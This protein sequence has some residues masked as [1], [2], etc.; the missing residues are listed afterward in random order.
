MSSCVRCGCLSKSCSCPGGMLIGDGRDDPT[1]DYARE[2]VMR[3]RAAAARKAPTSTPVPEKKQA[4]RKCGICSGAEG[5]THVGA[6]VCGPC[7][8]KFREPISGAVQRCILCT[9]DGKLGVDAT[10]VVHD[11]L[12]LCSSHAGIKT[13]PATKETFRVAGSGACYFCPAVSKGPVGVFDPSGRQ[14]CLK[15]LTKFVAQLAS[16]AVAAMQ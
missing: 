9:I 4:R 3:E 12:P 6:E 5:F 16:A 1:G 8:F 11:K 7:I 2:L 10:H 14:I 15:C 13:P